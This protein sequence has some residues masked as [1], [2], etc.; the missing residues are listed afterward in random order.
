MLIKDQFSV[1]KKK[2][3]APLLEERQVRQISV[4]VGTTGEH[5][6]PDVGGNQPFKAYYRAKYASWRKEHQSEHT[7]SGYHRKPGRQK[8]IDMM[9]HAWSQVTSDFVKKTFVK[10]R[11]LIQKLLPSILLQ[12]KKFVI[13]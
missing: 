3:S 2:C 13:L 9:P 5:K 12:A 6:P 11:S 1:H 7:K 4:P 10:P 8:I